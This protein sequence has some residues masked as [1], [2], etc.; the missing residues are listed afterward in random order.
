[1]SAHRE[2]YYQELGDLA[3]SWL[4]AENDYPQGLIA[5]WLAPKASK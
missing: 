3:F 1:M 4:M 2:D 5:A